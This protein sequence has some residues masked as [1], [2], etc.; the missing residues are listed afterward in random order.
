M[1]QCIECLE[2][3]P[4]GYR[5]DRLLCSAECKRKRNIRLTAER[6]ARRKEENLEEFLAQRRRQ[7]RNRLHWRHRSDRRS[8]GIK[9]RHTTRMK[10][11]RKC[12]GLC[13]ECGGEVSLEWEYPHPGSW[14]MDHAI[15]LCEGGDHSEENLVLTH[16]ICNI[17]KGAKDGWKRRRAQ[18]SRTDDQLESS[19]T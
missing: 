15:P 3:I 13:A 6:S 11:Y 10:I 4:A 9:I 17:K 12:F 7:A 19:S 5:A 2:S 14:S 18:E 8:R 1:K 16:L